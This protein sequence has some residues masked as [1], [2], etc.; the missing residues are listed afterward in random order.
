LIYVPY[1]YQFQAAY[2]VLD[3]Y[4]ATA[5]L[6]AESTTDFNNPIYLVPWFVTFHVLRSLGPDGSEFLA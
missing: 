5:T 4:P 1:Q 2:Y 6:G 3:E